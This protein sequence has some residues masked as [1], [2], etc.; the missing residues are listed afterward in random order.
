MVG[1]ASLRPRHAFV[2][3]ALLLCANLAAWANDTFTLDRAF[4][5]YGLY[6][7]S[8]VDRA[9]EELADVRELARTVDDGGQ[10]WGDWNYWAA[11][12]DVVAGDIDAALE[13]IEV[14]IA[15]YRRIDSKIDLAHS[16]QVRGDSYAA[17]GRY[18]ESIADHETVIEMALTLE[19]RDFFLGDAWSSLGSSYTVQGD[20]GAALEA[21]V[22]SYDAYRRQGDEESLQ[23]VYDL[24]GNV[25]SEL[26]EQDRALAVYRESLERARASGDEIGLAI[27]HYNAGR[28]LN[29]LG[30]TVDARAEFNTALAL[31][32]QSND[33]FSIAWIRY[34]LAEGWIED[35]EPVRA[36]AQLDLA[37][38]LASELGDRLLGA[39][40]YYERCRAAALSGD[41]EAALELGARAIG[42]LEDSDDQK[43]LV[44]VYAALTAS[45]ERLGRFDRA[46]DYAQRRMALMERFSSAERARRVAQLRVELDTSRAEDEA[47][48]RAELLATQVRI[49]RLVMALAAVL[50]VALLAVGYSLFRQKRLEARL[51]TMANTDDLTGVLSRRRLFQLA[52]RE[53]QRAVRYNRPLCALLLDLDHFKKVN[54]D[55]GHPT[56]DE[57]L[58][59]ISLAVM[60][61]LR[62][63][64]FIGRIGGEEFLVVLPETPREAA[65]EAARRLVETVRSCNHAD[66]GVDRAITMSVGLTEFQG[67]GDTLVQM[68]RR[69]DAA[70]Y[71]A[72]TDGR[73][74]ALAD[75]GMA[76]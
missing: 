62:D 41:H 55:Y 36:R 72:K 25:Y 26:D 48:L 17:L 46:F 43:H 58:A 31:S 21:L 47:R 65:L 44:D 22:E 71:R 60:G 1:A 2:L 42:P 5:R 75:W 63:T 29:Q 33:T 61:S 69:A 34:G 52:E 73:D 32:E 23:F 45:A 10:Y 64:D 3:A 18:R 7:E 54:D 15:V 4:E 53:L 13:T 68:T 6:V 66:S 49:N 50:G 16:L 11:E 8:D 39:L 70:L 38:Q 76:T 40:V 24:L 35:G 19:D 28:A 9:R 57:V 56:G 14:A 51:K 67:A 30:R 20:F 27:G 59:R 74:Q 12:A 37:E